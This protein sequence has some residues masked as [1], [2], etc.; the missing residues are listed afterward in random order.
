MTQSKKE[1]KELV[2]LNLASI[3]ER[4]RQTLG[5]YPF[6]DVPLSTLSEKAKVDKVYLASGFVLVSILLASYFGTGHLIL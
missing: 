6:I 5:K 1:Q 4:L 2:D 3:V